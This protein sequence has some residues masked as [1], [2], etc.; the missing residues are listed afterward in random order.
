MV[1]AFQPM[2]GFIGGG[3]NNDRLLFAA[4]AALLFVVARAMRRGVVVRLAASAGAALAV[5]LL[6]KATMV[7]LFPAA[8]LGLLLAVWSGCRNGRP[9]PWKGAGEHRGPAPKHASAIWLRRSRRWQVSRA[10]PPGIPRAPT[11]SPRAT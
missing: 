3:V 4:S 10:R 11:A 5:G 2:L 7:A 1:A 9:V 6:T 8:A